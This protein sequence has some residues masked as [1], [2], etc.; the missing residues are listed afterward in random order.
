MRPKNS[1]SF[2]SAQSSRSSPPAS[3]NQDELI[4][5]PLSSSSPSFR[6][7][8]NARPLAS[9]IQRALTFRSS[10][11][12][13]PPSVYV[14]SCCVVA[15][16]DVPDAGAA[17]EVDPGGQR[18]LAEEVLEAA[19]VE[20]VGVDGQAARRA[21]LDALGQLAVVAGGEPEAQ[22]VLR[23]LLVLEV[24]LEAEHV[25]EVLAGDLLRRLADLEGGLARR[26]LALLGDEDAG[27]GALPA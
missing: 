17:D 18:L 12:S 21:A 14:I 19:A 25:R 11:L 22:A 8:V 7:S 24:L 26:P 3:L 15:E 10:V 13:L 23:D 5:W 20:L 9:R 1:S 6:F 27:V 4:T 2:G 16:L